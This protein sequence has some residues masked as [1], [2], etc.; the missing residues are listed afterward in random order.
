MATAIA[1]ITKE[2]IMKVIH[3]WYDE[4]YNDLKQEF[5]GGGVTLPSLVTV[6]EDDDYWIFWYNSEILYKVR[7]TDK[8]LLLHSGVTDEGW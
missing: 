1:K 3:E 6:S 5:G 7:K 2:N 4:N 8:Q